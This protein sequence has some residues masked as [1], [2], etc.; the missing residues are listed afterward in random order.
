MRFPD[1]REMPMKFVFV[2]IA[3]PKRLVWEQAEP[4]KHGEGPPECR[5]SVTLEPFG[6]GTR[7][8][9]VAQFASLKERDASVSMGFTGRIAASNDRFDAYLKSMGETQ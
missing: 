9:L 2:E 1:G 7:W 5:F 4:G 3:P 8:T 6:N